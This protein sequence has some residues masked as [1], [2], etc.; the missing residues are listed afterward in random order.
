MTKHSVLSK[1]AKMKYSPEGQATLFIKIS[2]NN[3]EIFH[4]K[5]FL[6]LTSD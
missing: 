5:G 4:P 3:H 1:A 6:T 2:F